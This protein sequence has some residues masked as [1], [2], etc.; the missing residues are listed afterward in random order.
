[1]EKEKNLEQIIEE[2]AIVGKSK[3]IAIHSFPIRLSAK[4][5]IPEQML[6]LD[7]YPKKDVNDK[8]LDKTD[9]I[10]KVRSLNF[11]LNLQ[12]LQTCNLEMNQHI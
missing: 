5:N 2:I 8:R 11:L 9:K 7:N 6:N 3:R 12:T 4:Y 10:K 1:M